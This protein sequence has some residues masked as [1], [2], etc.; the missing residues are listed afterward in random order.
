MKKNNRIWEIDFLRGIA[1]ICMVY[2][3]VVFDLN[4]IFG[5]NTIQLDFIGDFSAIIFMLLCGISTTLSKNCL[6]RGALVFGAAMLLTAVTFAVDMIFD[7]RLIIVFGILHMLGIAM[8]LSYLVKKM[9]NILI[10]AVSAVL[11]ALYIPFKNIRNMGNLL[12]AFGIHDAKFYS[13]DYYPLIPYL[14][15]VFIGI[16][17]GK[18]LYSD[19]KSIFSFSLGNNPVSF[20][21]QHSLIL[22]L[23]HQPIV[24][25]I[26]FIIL[27]IAGQ[28]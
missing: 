3:H 11:F 12:F 1:F 5:V 26:L 10:A 27:K 13:S 28:I 21:G 15:V 4:Y 18:L 9:P 6:K 2:D 19:R 25:A 22:Y 24:I 20:I 17:M 14:G 8:M 16:I 7:T 23:T